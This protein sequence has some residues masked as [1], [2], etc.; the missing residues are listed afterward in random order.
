MA[1]PRLFRPALVC[2]VG[3]F[4]LAV[5]EIQPV[6]ATVSLDGDVVDIVTWNDFPVPWSGPA[7]FHRDLAFRGAT[8]WL[9]DRDGPSMKLSIDAEGNLEV[10]EGAPAEPYADD[11]GHRYIAPVIPEVE[12]L[13]G[14]AN[15]L[16]KTN[17]DD[18]SRYAATVRVEGKGAAQAWELGRGSVASH[19]VGAEGSA[20][21][22]VRRADKVPT[23]F[24]AKHELYVLFRDANGGR[25]GSRRIADV[26]IADLCW[27]PRAT[28]DPLRRVR[29]YLDF[30]MGQCYDAL[31][32]G[33][34]DVQLKVSDM[35]RDPVVEITFS[36]D[37]FPGARFRIVDRPVDELGNYS[38][39]LREENFFLD[40]R[41]FGSPLLSHVQPDED[42]FIDI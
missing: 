28:E 17:S 20:A 35:E 29:D 40:E 32:A 39:G 37:R 22:A 9:T 3:H 1:G 23:V 19:A 12:E 24:R 6:A 34:H 30:S 31:R 25:S 10:S 11:I 21:V 16:F 27:P 4:Y 2:P 33:G 8:A 26:D 38:S 5:D 7:D 41:L 36:W 15:W 42:G 14:G 13:S 18:W